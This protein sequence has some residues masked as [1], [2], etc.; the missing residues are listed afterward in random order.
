ML[1]EDQCYLFRPLNVKMK[2]ADGVAQVV[3]NVL[4]KGKAL[5]SNPVLPKHQQ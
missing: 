1:K 5:N 2:Y 3:E 4:T